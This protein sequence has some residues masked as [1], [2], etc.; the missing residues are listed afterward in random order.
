MTIAQ[1]AARVCVESISLLKKLSPDSESFVP[2]TILFLSSASCAPALS[3]SQGKLA[4][5][6]LH[7][8]ALYYIYDDLERAQRYLELPANRWIPHVIVCP[9]GLTEGEPVG[10]TISLEPSDVGMLT[11]ADLGAGMLDIAGDTEKWKGKMVQPS[12]IKMPD[13][14]Q[15]GVLARYIFIGLLC[16]FARPLWRLG[17][18]AGWW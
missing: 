13:N 4:H 11:Y 14:P 1:D 2:P 17:R 5:W 8:L 6:I 9:N 12:G 7:E 18:W 10:H 16:R 3:Q 15:V